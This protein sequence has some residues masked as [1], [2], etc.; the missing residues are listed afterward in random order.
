MFKFTTKNI[1]K[2]IKKA[3]KD[4]QDE[5]TNL[6]AERRILTKRM[7]KNFKEETENQRM[8]EMLTKLK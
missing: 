6:Q 8:I 2:F 3:L 4:L 5:R 1:G 7:E